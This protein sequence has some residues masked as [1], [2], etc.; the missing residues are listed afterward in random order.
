MMD[1]YPDAKYIETT[2]TVTNAAMISINTRMGFYDKEPLKFYEI[3][4]R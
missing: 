3:K 4:I 1:N 2:N